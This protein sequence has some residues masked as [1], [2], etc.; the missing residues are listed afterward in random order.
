MAKSKVKLTKGLV[1][2]I[3]DLKPFPKNP[4]RHTDFQIQELA[5]SLERYGQYKPIRVDEN[6]MIL[7]GHGTVE[8]MKRL[9]WSE[10]DC[11]RIEGL[12]EKQKIKMVIEDNKIQSLS[13]IQMP[14][15]D[16]LIKEIG[17][18]DIIG[19]NMD[20]LEGIV[21]STS[22]D[23]MGIDFNA[24]SLEGMLGGNNT[25]SESPSGSHEQAQASVQVGT[26]KVSEEQAQ[27]QEKAFANAFD[28][29]SM[30]YTR[31]VVCPHCGKEFQ[32]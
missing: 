8:A 11:I 7:G 22:I 23:N 9:G 18:T 20:Y 14:I 4:N 2:P 17:D 10:A 21:N 27:M 16:E 15:Q 28:P 30:A 3:A 6:N 31:T 29:A 26:A 5:K 12:N 13:I 1:L 25:P 19:F 24:G 32:I